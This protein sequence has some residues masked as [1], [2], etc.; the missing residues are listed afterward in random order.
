MKNP[1]VTHVVRVTSQVP[2]KAKGDFSNGHV[3]F[4]LSSW[5]PEHRSFRT[6]VDIVQRTEGNV[7]RAFDDISGVRSCLTTTR[8][9]RA[10]F[11]SLCV[12][13]TSD[14]DYKK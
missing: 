5:Q 1:A 11:A 7:N 12:V 13:S 10:V 9:C 8:H 14:G 4:D 6:V 3:N 2:R